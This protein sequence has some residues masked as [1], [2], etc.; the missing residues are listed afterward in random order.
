MSED[1]KKG[2]HLVR[3]E[4]FGMGGKSGLFTIG[5]TDV[6][7][8]YPASICRFPTATAPASVVQ[9]SPLSTPPKP[10]PRTYRKPLIFAESQSFGCI[11]Y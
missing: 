6:S 4:G 8:V 5:F 3:W 1:L 2:K 9:S 7:Q 11:V 10:S